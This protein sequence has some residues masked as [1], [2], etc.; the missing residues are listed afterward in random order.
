MVVTVVGGVGGGS[1]FRSR[2]G[3]LDVPQMQKDTLLRNLLSPCTPP[4]ICEK[5]QK[6]SKLCFLDMCTRPG[7]Q[8]VKKKKDATGVFL[9]GHQL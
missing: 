3:L 1:E 7:G 6:I 9:C 5:Y 2:L 8:D 4:Q